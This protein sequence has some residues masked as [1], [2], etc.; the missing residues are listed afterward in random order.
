MFKR[1]WIVMG[2]A[3]ALGVVLSA[4]GGNKLAEE[5]TPIPTLPKGQ[6]PTL[7]DALQGITPTVAEQGGQMTQEQ[8]VAMGEQLFSSVC[9]ACHK[10]QD[11]VGPAFTGMAER[12]ASRIQGVSAEGYIRQ[13]ILDPSA[14][15]VTGFSDVM[16]KNF[17]QQ[18]TDT[19]INALIAYIMAKSGSAATP[20]AAQEATQQATPEATQAATQAPT[21]PSAQA[22][23]PVAPSAAATQPPA[24]T[25]TT[26]SAGDPAAGEQL[27]A[28]K[29]SGCHGATDGIAPGLT[30]M[31]K[32]AA[33]RIAG[34]S[35]EE[36]IRQSI[37]EPGTFVVPSFKDIMPKTFGQQLS[38]TDIDN[39]IAYILTQQG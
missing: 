18:Y 30:G 12:A 7:V 10:A 22:A 2:V 8:L 9:S 35:A 25:G 29:C 3:L 27:F 39:V 31:G 38:Q 11:S 14:F 37:L 4:C 19:Q 1:T 21:R 5:L 24:A 15:V 17:R 26:V 23:T 28:S 34:M 13:S 32:R 20:V 36:Y 6:E 16:T 33:A